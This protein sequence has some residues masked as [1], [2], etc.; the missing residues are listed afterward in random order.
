M[1]YLPTGADE[2]TSRRDELLVI[3]QERL[4]LDREQLRIAKR[5]AVFE[6]IKMAFT[7]AVPVAAFFGLHRYFQAQKKKEIP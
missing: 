3:A 4:A 6:G 7:I 5:A 1:A 2:E